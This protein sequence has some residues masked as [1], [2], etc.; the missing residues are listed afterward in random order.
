M[1]IEKAI[2]NIEDKLAEYE[3]TNEPEDRL[4]IKQDIQQQIKS[5]YKYFEESG[6]KMNTETQ[7]AIHDFEEILSY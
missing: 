3:E 5:I 7:Q 4:E 1:N 6:K 2:F